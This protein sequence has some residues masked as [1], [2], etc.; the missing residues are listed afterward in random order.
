[1]KKKTILILGSS[2]LLGKNLYKKFKEKN[3]NVLGSDLNIEDLKDKNFYKVDFSN[4]GQ[5]KKLINTVNRKY[6]SIDIVVNAIYP[7]NT[8]KKTS[9]FQQSKKD[10]LTKVTSH[11]SINFLI[12]K[13]FISYFLK[14]KLKGNIIHISSVYGS[15]IP[16]FEIYKKQKFTMPLD[17]L[18]AK[19]SM[20]YST[21]YLSK[22][23][24]GSKI[25][26][27]NISPG[28]VFDNQDKNFVKKYSKYTNNKAMLKVEDIF[29][30]VN[31]LAF[32]KNL[33]I[34]GQ[35]FIVD[36]GFSL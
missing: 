13:L 7:K 9:F 12:N 10:F 24:L 11:L 29:D 22:I 20:D 27:N 35:N 36:D 15:F 5:V 16:R 30:I 25:V 26:I 17:Y 18:I 14:N 33:K 28:G 21:K 32:A 1:M 8:K 4:E 34:T 23:L 19:S 2:G 31:F 6:K 3:C